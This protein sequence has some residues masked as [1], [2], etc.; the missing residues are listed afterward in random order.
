[1]NGSPC[2]RR[3]WLVRHARALGAEGRCYG[4]TDLA[5]DRA[6]TGRAA[7]ALAV[8]LPPGARLQV[9]PAGRTQALAQALQALRPDLRATTDPRLQELNFG[10]WEGML[11]DA[12]SRADLD[13][14]VA[15]FATHRP[16][17]GESVA[18][19][20]TRVAPALAHADADT[21]SPGGGDAVWITHAGV[22]RAALWLRCHGPAELPRAGNW[23]ALTPGWG[24]WIAL[25]VPA[26]RFVGLQ[27]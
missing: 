4:R 7:Q 9:S 26:T 10:C 6:E 1:M 16:G 18:D 13:A 22:I 17:G 15:D 3:L 20:L 25:P 24:R 11:W 8:A 2:G 23:P 14:W 27:G 21:R 19:L 5:A 12:I